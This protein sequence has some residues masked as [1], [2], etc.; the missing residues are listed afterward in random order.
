MSDRI[1]IVPDIL[2]LRR[3][4]VEFAFMRDQ[5]AFL[6]SLRACVPDEGTARSALVLTLAMLS[7]FDRLGAVEERIAL[8]PDFYLHAG[9]LLIDLILVRKDA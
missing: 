4:A 1:S 5:R 9:D 7:A 6:E 8:A 2:A 3:C